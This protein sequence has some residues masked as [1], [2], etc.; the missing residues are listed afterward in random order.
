MMRVTIVLILAAVFIALGCPDALLPG[1]AP[2][3]MRA[4]IYPLFHANVWHLL[5]NVVSMWGIL[6]RRSSFKEL[7]IAYVI[8]ILVYPLSFRPVVGI[9]NVMY[10]M[11]GM[12]SPC[13]SSAWWRTAPVAAFLAVTIVMVFIPQF[14]ATTHVASFVLGI[15]VAYARRWKNSVLKDAGLC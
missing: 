13:L 9:S 4:M 6:S 11:L 1:G 5:V 3:I 14:S 2:Y 15:F 8:S 7:A 12:R 10:A